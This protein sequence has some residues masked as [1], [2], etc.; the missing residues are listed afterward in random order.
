[1][2]YGANYK[3]ISAVKAGRVRPKKQGK[4]IRNH[5]AQVDYRGYNSVVL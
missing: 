2:A 1:M 5:Y 3:K 4:V